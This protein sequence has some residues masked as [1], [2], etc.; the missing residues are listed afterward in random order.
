MSQ[1]YEHRWWIRPDISRSWRVREYVAPA[2]PPVR[3][4]PSTVILRYYHAKNPLSRRLPMPLPTFGGRQPFG[5]NIGVS[6]PCL[7]TRSPS[8]FCEFDQPDLA[9]FPKGTHAIS[10]HGL[11][12]L[13]KS[14]QGSE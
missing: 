1:V 4:P 9:I 12:D 13:L 3:E 7:L 6:A 2:S 5:S 11:V 10:R 14:T 8:V